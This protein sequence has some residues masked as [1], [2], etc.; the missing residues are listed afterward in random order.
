MGQI[1]IDPTVPLFPLMGASGGRG[2]SLGHFRD[3][4]CLGVLLSWIW[5]RWLEWYDFLS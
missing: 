5:K 3:S 4:G 2:I 1:G